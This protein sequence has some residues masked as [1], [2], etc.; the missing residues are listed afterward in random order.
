[1]FWGQRWNRAFRDA[2]YGSLFLP[3][4]ERR[5]PVAGVAAVFLFSGIVHEVAISVP[6]AVDMHCPR[7]TLRCNVRLCCW[8]TRGPEND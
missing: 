3:V 8:R 1:M 6:R 7:F 2:C 5:G 4:V